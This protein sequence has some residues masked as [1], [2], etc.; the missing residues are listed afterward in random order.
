MWR[1][2]GRQEG[3]RNEKEL[4]LQHPLKGPSRALRRGK[5]GWVE[6]QLKHSK[7]D[8]E[9]SSEYDVTLR[10]AEKQVV[11]RPRAMGAVGRA[12]RVAGRSRR[13]RWRKTNSGGVG[14][15]IRD[16]RV[17]AWVKPWQLLRNEGGVSGEDPDDVM[18]FADEL[19][20]ELRLSRVSPPRGFCD[21]CFRPRRVK[22]D[23][24]AEEPR[25]FYRRYAVADLRWPEITATSATNS[26][27]PCAKG[28][29]TTWCQPP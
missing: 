8:N 29:P 27:K 10:L 11:E 5:L 23:A 1:E 17:V 14:V 26:A 21:P 3:R 4:V 9:L 24:K 25:S 15:E 20:V 22:T 18:R 2:H 28:L 12:G 16:A 6:R 19:G 7:Y 13:R